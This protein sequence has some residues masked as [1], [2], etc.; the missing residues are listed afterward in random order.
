MPNKN[1]RLAK[2]KT[3][4]S[5]DIS[6]I[7]SHKATGSTSNV[8]VSDTLRKRQNFNIVQRP[9]KQ[10]SNQ[11]FW[12]ELS[13]DDLISLSNIATTEANVIFAMSSFP[14]FANAAAFFDQYC[15]YCVTITLSTLLVEASFGAVQCYTAFDYDS[16]ANIGKAAIQ[17]YGSY[18]FTSLAP[19]GQSSLVRLLKPCIAPQVTSSNVPVPGGVS[20]QWLDVAY[21]S[22]QHYGFRNIFDT[23]S[24]SVTN[25]VHRNYTAIVGLRNN[26]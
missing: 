23:Y 18:N 6:I 26:V 13:T 15:I 19:G 12:C 16:A 5:T 11:I 4:N 17:G 25:A 10:L 20:R 9:P 2:G 22:V 1:R 14:G 7:N 21:P 24:A 3:S 8:V